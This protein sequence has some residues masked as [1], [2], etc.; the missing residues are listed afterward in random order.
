MDNIIR[1]AS[2]LGASDARWV[3]AD[4]I[5]VEDGL[6]RL[7]ES[8]RCPGYGQSPHCPPHVMSPRAFREILRSYGHAL[9]FKFDVPTEILLGNERHE[10]N[11]AVHETAS[12]IQAFAAD[13]GYANPMGLAAGSCKRVFCHDHRDCPALARNGRCRFPDSARPSMSGLGIN[14][15]ELAKLLGWQMSKITKNS[16]PNEAPMGLMAGMVLMG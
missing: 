14:F 2:E 13:M 12:G 16:D 10:I 7:C 1:Y 11:R 5:I 9:V 15:L 3:S 6:A 8:P 4:E